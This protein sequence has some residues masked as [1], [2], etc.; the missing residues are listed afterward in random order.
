MKDLPGPQEYEQ[1][2]ASQAISR[3]KS[4]TT[5]MQAFGTT[6]RRFVG[7]TSQSVAVPGPGTYKSERHQRM[8]ANFAVHRVRGQLVKVKKTSKESASFLSLIHI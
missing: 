4:W 7:A 8:A 2:T 6:E 3:G 5:T 1:A